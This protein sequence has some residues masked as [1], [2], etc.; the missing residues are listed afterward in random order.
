MAIEIDYTKLT[1]RD[2]KEL[3]EAAGT[4]NLKEFM[5]QLQEQEPGAMAAICWVLKRQQTPGFTLDDAFEL[6]MDDLTELFGK[7]APSGAESAPLTISSDPSAPSTITPR[8]SSGSSQ[9]KTRA[10]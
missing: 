6:T 8:G 7:N 10:S 9:P 4:R 1:L 2:Q 5:A 3:C